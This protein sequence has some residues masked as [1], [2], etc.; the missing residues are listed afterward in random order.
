MVRT[1]NASVATE[2]RRLN[3]GLQTLPSGRSLYPVPRH[4][5]F[6]R[7][8]NQ[9][10]PEL[11]SDFSDRGLPQARAG[12]D[13]KSFTFHGEGQGSRFTS[14]KSTKSAQV[15]FV[16]FA[17]FEMDGRVHTAGEMDRLMHHVASSKY[18]CARPATFDEYSEK[19]IL[20]LPARNLS[21]RDIVFVGPGATGCELYH[22]N[23]LCA[24]KCV[25]PPGEHLDGTWDTASL[26]GRK[27]VVCVYPVERVKR[28]QSLTQFGLARSTIGESGKLR[29]AG[30]L[31]GLMDKTHWTSGDFGGSTSQ[32]Q[33]SVRMDQFFR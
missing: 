32:A 29:R 25:V 18:P 26:Y 4:S 16:G 33:R 23:T 9:K 11:W 13:E 10:L 6:H 28:Q 30:S 12:V 27:T 31:A 3:S 1:G 22:S 21:G 14:P 17:E 20:G 7:S 15:V 24:Q 19:S 2:E 8:I 5:E